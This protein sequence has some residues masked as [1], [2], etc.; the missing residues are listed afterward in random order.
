MCDRSI[1]VHGYIGSVF[2]SFTLLPQIVHTFRKKK[3]DQL[4]PIFLLNNFVG[5]FFMMV[6]AV[7]ETLVP[8][9]VTNAMILTFTIT[10]TILYMLSLIHI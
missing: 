3:V 5:T 6:Y 9:I 7:Q 4:S 10:L 2:I 8:I 1:N